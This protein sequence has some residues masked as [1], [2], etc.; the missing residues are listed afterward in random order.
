MLQYGV[1]DAALYDSYATGVRGDVEFHVSMARLANGPVIEMGCGTGRILIPIASEG[2]D[3]T[4]VDREQ[5]MLDIAERK[6]ADEKPKGKVKLMKGD[7]RTFRSEVPYSLIIVAYRT[8]L[9]LTEPGSMRQALNTMRENLAPDGRLILSFFDPSIEF[10]VEYI[11]PIE[12]N[13]IKTVRRFDHPVSDRPVVMSNRR[14]VNPESQLV[15]TES[16]FEEVGTQITVVPLT[17]R[18]VFRYEM[19][20]LLELC[21]LQPEALYGDFSRGPYRYGGEQIWVARKIAT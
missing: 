13:P 10:M 19:E 4:G 16:I 20:H 8:F 9:H 3:I 21:G 5:A 15:T 11:G 7:L 1:N 18:Y 12:A 6:V 2:V 14:S 17:L